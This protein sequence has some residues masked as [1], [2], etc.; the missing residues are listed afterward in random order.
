MGVSVVQDL[1]VALF[2]RK[3]CSPA[4]L[5]TGVEEKRKS[6]KLRKANPN[7]GEEKSLQRISPQIN[8]I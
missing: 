8:E 2:G 1:D 6:A 4:A 7:E 5:G 3:L